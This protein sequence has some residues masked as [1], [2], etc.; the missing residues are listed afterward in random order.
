MTK[1]L[2]SDVVKAQTYTERGVQRS[3][4]LNKKF[5]VKIDKNFTEIIGIG[6]SGNAC[7]EIEVDDEINLSSINSIILQ[8]KALKSAHMKSSS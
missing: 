1:F 3:N 8:H 5:L 2:G 6:G 7:A 4:A